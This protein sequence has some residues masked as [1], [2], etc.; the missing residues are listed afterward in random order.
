MQ[1]FN[2]AYPDYDYKPKCLY[3]KHKMRKYYECFSSSSTLVSEFVYNKYDVMLT[4]RCSLTQYRDYFC[5]SAETSGHSEGCYPLG[6]RVR[7]FC[8]RSCLVNYIWK[9]QV[10]K[11]SVFDYIKGIEQRLKGDCYASLFWPVHD[12]MMIRYEISPPALDEVYI[13]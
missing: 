13:L 10:I 6:C 8:L 3:Y 1:Y 12:Y 9:I 7:P 2:S 11:C 4:R 5:E